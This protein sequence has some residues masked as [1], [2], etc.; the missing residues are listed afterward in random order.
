MKRN[1]FFCSTRTELATG[2]PV[3][4]AELYQHL[5]GIRAL[6][7][8]Q[9]CKKDPSEGDKDSTIRILRLVKYN[10]VDDCAPP[11]PL[12]IP[13]NPSALV[14]IRPIHPFLSR[15]SAACTTHSSTWRIGQQSDEI[16]I[17]V[18]NSCSRLSFV[19]A[20]RQ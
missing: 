10:T 4:T 15:E 7:S 20:C 2:A 13:P 16:E 1:P 8:N 17:V 11:P 12:L 18:L 14:P 3:H 6:F 9:E 5:K 19:L